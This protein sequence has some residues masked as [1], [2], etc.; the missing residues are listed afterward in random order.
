M[1]LNP[2]KIDT[3][4]RDKHLCK[5]GGKYFFSNATGAETELKGMH[6]KA[7]KLKGKYFFQFDEGHFMTKFVDVET[8]EDDF[9]LL[10]SGLLSFEDLQ[11]KCARA[12]S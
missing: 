1:K 10:R 9:V 7:Y 12:G 4:Q 11:H 8:T 6:C 5:R 2:V 3:S